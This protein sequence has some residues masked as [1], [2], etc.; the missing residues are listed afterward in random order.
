L[1][2]VR[3]ATKGIKMSS[4]PF[5]VT[6]LEKK[7]LRIGVLGEF[8]SGKTAFILS[9]CGKEYSIGDLHHWDKAKTPLFRAAK[10]SQPGLDLGII[11]EGD[12]TLYL[13]GNPSSTLINAEWFTKEPYL[14]ENLAG[15]IIIIDCAR[16]FPVSVSAVYKGVV[17]E[18]QKMNIAYVVAANGQDVPNAQSP[19]T[20]RRIFQFD[21]QIKV[22]PCIAHDQGSV[23]FVLWNL[24]T[25]L[26]ESAERN[27]FAEKIKKNIPAPT[28]Q[29]AEQ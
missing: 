10:K 13:F 4:S 9:A 2:E 24:L 18:V 1:F 16:H 20:I 19:E 29:W 21:P 11:R 14:V 28:L 15:V 22:L 27:V 5:N 26:P 23:S 8:N 3:G 7:S 25:I 12:L 6:V 17:S